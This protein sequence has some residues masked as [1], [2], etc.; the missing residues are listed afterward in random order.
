MTQKPISSDDMGVRRFVHHI[1]N[2][3]QNR[4]SELFRARLG[5]I[6]VSGID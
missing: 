4:K 3:L 1:P 2:V 5:L 6:L